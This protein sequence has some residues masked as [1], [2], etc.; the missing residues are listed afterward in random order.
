[1]NT[2]PVRP[3]TDV[4]RDLGRGHVSDEASAALTDLVQSVVA[5]GKKGRVTIH[6]EV[7]P[8]KGSTTTLMVSARVDSK[9]PQAE[10][11]AAVFFPDRNGQ[12]H[13]NH[14]DQPTFEELQN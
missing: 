12:L 5:T 7:E 1:M 3:F 10:P 11:V 2:Q 4:L 6:V 9:M 8:F 13:R 14:P